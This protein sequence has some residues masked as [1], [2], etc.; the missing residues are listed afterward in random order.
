M[1]YRVNPEI[2][3]LSKVEETRCAGHASTVV[4]GLD[5]DKCRAIVCVSGD[6]TVCEVLNALMTLPNRCES[7]TLD[8]ELRSHSCH[9]L[10][11]SL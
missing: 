9:A 1:A 2:S 10:K 4:S 11:F 3:T 8:P 7:S 5:F 6:G